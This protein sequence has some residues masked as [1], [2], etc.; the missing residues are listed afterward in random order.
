MSTWWKSRNSDDHS[1]SKL[2]PQICNV[3]NLA[4]SVPL[5][6]STFFNGKKGFKKGNSRLK[7]N[8]DC[9]PHMEVSSMAPNPFDNVNRE[10][11]SFTTQATSSTE[12]P[13]SD[14][15]IN[16]KQTIKI[17]SLDGLRQRLLQ[18]EISDTFSKLISITRFIV[19]LQFVLVKAGLLVW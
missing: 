13:G 18:T 15:S 14:T 7:K 11:T 8:V 1:E 12:P 3:V 10:T 2:L 6:F 4:Q 17:S 19:K 5:S 9:S 16:N